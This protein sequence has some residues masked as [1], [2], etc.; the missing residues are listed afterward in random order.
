MRSP[1][2]ENF[3]NV[4][5]YLDVVE[6]ERLVFTDALTPGFRP[7]AKPFMTAIV[8]MSDHNGGTKYVARALHRSPED[9]KSHEEMGFHDGWGT[10]LDQLVAHVKSKM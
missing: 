3:P 10:A 1:E 6:Y 2:G 4:G 9:R 7:A 8:T 5:C